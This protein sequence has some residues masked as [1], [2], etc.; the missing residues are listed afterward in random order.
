MALAEKRRAREEAIA[1]RMREL[2]APSPSSRFGNWRAVDN[3]LY[4]EG[5]YAAPFV[6]LQGRI[7][8][9]V[10]YSKTLH[11]YVM[12]GLKQLLFSVDIK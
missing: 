1:E 10:E 7:V 2:L 5:D 9:V 12:D 8:N 3:H 11:I 6:V 4:R